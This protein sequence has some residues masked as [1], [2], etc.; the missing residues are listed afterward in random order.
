MKVAVRKDP[1]AGWNR[2][3]QV[4]DF[5]L[6]PEHASTAHISGEGY[7]HLFIDGKK[8]GRLC[9]EWYHIPALTPGI[10]KINRTRTH[11]ET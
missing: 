1:K 3:V 7:A 10:H 9:G 2:Q 5:R 4:E 6:A 8:G 11:T